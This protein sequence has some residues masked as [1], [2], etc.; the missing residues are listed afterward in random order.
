MPKRMI[1]TAIDVM[2]HLK[3]AGVQSPA[4]ITLV[5]R[6]IRTFAGGAEGTIKRYL[7]FLKFIEFIKDVGKDSDDCVMV[8]LN[9]QKVDELCLG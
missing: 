3:T 6:T 4:P 9:W 2:E 7:D 8:E 1:D 5:I